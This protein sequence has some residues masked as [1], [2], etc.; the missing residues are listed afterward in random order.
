M[1]EVT[2]VEKV[3]TYNELSKEAKAKVKEWYLEGQEPEIYEEMILE[4]IGE[5]FPN[6][7]L[8]VQFSLSNCQGDGVNIYGE[9]N[10]KDLIFHTKS[11]LFSKE[12]LSTL[13]VYFNILKVNENVD[14]FS[15][16]INPK[17]SYCMADYIVFKNKLIYLL[18]N[19]INEND[20]NKWLLHKFSAFVK[21]FITDLCEGFEK[22]G[23]NYFYEISEDDLK[24]VCDSNDYEFYED[25]TLYL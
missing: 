7:D 18:K 25:G 8:K 20:I 2:I 19:Y 9:L 24:E 12:E 13:K 16:P 3:Y 11:S 14:S 5:L 21:T 15:L 1:R 23:Y 6:S 22:Y 10:F 17:Y 4:R